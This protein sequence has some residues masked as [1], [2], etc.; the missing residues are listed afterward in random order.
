MIAQ[1]F[2]HH[3][4]KKKRKTSTVVFFSGIASHWDGGLEK[5]NFLSNLVFEDG[6]GQPD[7]PS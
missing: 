6:I 3:R 1:I 4:F 7:R 5:K 2:T